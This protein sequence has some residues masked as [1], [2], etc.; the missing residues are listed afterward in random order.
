MCIRDRYQANS[1]TT[2]TGTPNNIMRT[3]YTQIAEQKGIY[4]LSYLVIFLVSHIPLVI[5]SHIS[6]HI[7]SRHFLSYLL[8]WLVISG[9]QDFSG[10]QGG[11][12]RENSAGLPL[13]I[14]IITPG[15]SKETPTCLQVFLKLCKLKTKPNGS[16]GRSTGRANHCEH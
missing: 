11:D 4:F 9:E 15:L 8:S 12:S 10:G 7:I 5:S 3:H 2:G 1:F 14:S 13:S 16:L 6:H